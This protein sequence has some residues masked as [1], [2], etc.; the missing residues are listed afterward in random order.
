M[1]VVKRDGRVEEFS[2]KKMIRAMVKAGAKLKDARKVASKAEKKFGTLEEISSSELR[3]FVISELEKLEK[4]VARSFAEFV[5]V[6][7]EIAEGEEMDKKL[8]ALC[9]E[10]GDVRHVYGGYEIEVR[11][12][13]GFD[14]P[15]VFIE[16]I[17]V[18]KMKVSVEEKDGRIV[19]IARP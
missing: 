17:K 6:R 8:V 7:R 11:N 14:Y 15:A 12:E 5:K 3:T 19:I 1:N 13:I 18:R 10:N 2:K 9:G 16:L 4:N